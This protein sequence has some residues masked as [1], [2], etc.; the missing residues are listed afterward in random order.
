MKIVIS[1]PMFFPWLGLFEQ[2]HLAD[3]YIHLD[4]VQMPG[5]QSFVH[6]VQLK[7]AT[8]AFWWHA[9]IYRQSTFSKISEVR[10]L[11]TADWINKSLKILNQ[12]FAK[13]P[14]K[15][16]ALA[17]FETV[18]NERHEYLAEFNIFFIELACQ[19]L[20]IQSRFKKI[21]R[22]PVGTNKTQKIIDILKE[23]DAS[24]YIS[25]LGGINYLE[26]SMFSK[27]AIELLFMDY[28]NTPYLQKYGMFNPFVSILHP[29]A[30]LGKETAHL[31]ISKATKR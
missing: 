6:R 15:A 30:A 20:E 4:D 27:N 28:K 16:D 29:I 14:Y 31:L 13:L 2:I 19:Y 21:Q 22:N 5:G 23:N 18:I 7:G 8:G 1:Q 11:L 25:G 26:S 12:I 9:P 17:L 3:T 10:L 24:V